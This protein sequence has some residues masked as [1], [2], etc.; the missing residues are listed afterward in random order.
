VGVKRYNGQA[1]VLCGVSLEVTPLHWFRTN[2]D[3]WQSF[4][5]YYRSRKGIELADPRQP[6][7]MANQSNM[8]PAAIVLPGIAVHALGTTLAQVDG[9]PP[10][11][12]L[13][14]GN[15]L[16]MPL[17]LCQLSGTFFKYTRTHRHTRTHVS[18]IV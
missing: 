15:C 11:V 3:K 16:F 14:L 4:A 18:R 10:G 5:D 17:D 7:A 2:G 6:M 13:A 9:A 1:Y 8:G 12:P